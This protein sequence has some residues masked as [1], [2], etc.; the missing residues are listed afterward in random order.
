MNGRTYA[1]IGLAVAVVGVAAALGPLG[2]TGAMTAGGGDEPAPV[3]NRRPGRVRRCPCRRRGTRRRGAPGRDDIAGGTRPGLHHRRR[4]GPGEAAALL[5]RPRGGEGGVAPPGSGGPFRQQEGRH[6]SG[7]STAQVDGRHSPPGP[8]GP[9]GASR[10]R[11]GRTLANNYGLQVESYNPAIENTRVWRRSRPSTPCC[12][13]G[14]AKR[15][16]TNRRPRLSMRTR[17]HL[18]SP[19]RV[20]KLLPSDAGQCP[21]GDFPPVHN[22]QPLSFS[23]S[24]RCGPAIRSSSCASRCCGTSAWTSTGLR[25]S[26][27]RTTA[28]QRPGFPARV[29]DLVRNVEEQYWQLVKA[30]R[31]S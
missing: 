22:P 8:A 3:V 14:Q 1:R 12:S 15:K 5:P 11:C 10:R 31:T 6:H 7:D 13:G 29:R 2:L 26:S 18:R 19:G 4:G 20:R 30:R 16:R 24:T 21:P 28:G 27:A 17:R 23:S 25:S 9:P